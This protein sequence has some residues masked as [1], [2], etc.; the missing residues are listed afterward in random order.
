MTNVYRVA[1]I[2]LFSASLAGCIIA[3]PPP[4]AYGYAAPGYYEP[5]YAVYP[6]V[7]L[8]LGFSFGGGG[9]RWR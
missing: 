4:P 5:G 7:S 1:A 6:P 3:E 9:H 8:G 2:V